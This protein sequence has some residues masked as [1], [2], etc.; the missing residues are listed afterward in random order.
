MAGCLLCGYLLRRKRERRYWGSAYR[1]DLVIAAHNYTRHF[2]SLKNV[3]VGDDVRFTDVDGNVFS[4]LVSE[5]EQLNP[6]AVE[7]LET[8]DWALTLFTCTL[9]G[10][11]RVVVRC[12]PAA[13]GKTAFLG[14]RS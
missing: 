1:D 9:G 8:G 10:Q 13:D 7:E 3:S 14:S 12:C 5:V 6:A 4:Y 11:Y 2:G